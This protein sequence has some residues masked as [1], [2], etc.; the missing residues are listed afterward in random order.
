MIFLE[1]E[2]DLILKIRELLRK[3][4]LNTLEREDLFR[5]KI[6]LSRLIDDMTERGI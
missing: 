5:L 2:I 3:P 1:A 4:E 6:E